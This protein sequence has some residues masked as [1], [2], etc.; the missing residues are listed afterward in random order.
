MRHS[1]RTNYSRLITSFDVHIQDAA[2]GEMPRCAA[3]AE[4]FLGDQPVGAQILLCETVEYALEVLGESVLNGYAP[5]GI[6]DLDTRAK[7]D[8]HVATPI[9][10]P[11]G[12]PSIASNRLVDDGD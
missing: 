8:V 1:R 12:L 11:L 2:I 3:V 9:V 4:E 5:D 6:Y 7:I 10:T